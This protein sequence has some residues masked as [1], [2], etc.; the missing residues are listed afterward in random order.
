MNPLLLLHLSKGRD[1]CQTMLD[2]TFETYHATD[3]RTG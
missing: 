1:V 2:G 3:K